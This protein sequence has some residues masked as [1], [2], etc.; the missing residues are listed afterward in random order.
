MT[1]PEGDCVIALDGTNVAVEG[2][3]CVPN[4]QV[5]DLPATIAT[6]LASGVEFTSELEADEDEQYRIATIQ[7]PEGNL[8]NLYDYTD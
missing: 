8:I 5:D 4:I 1:F 6:L 7:D 3:N 2:N